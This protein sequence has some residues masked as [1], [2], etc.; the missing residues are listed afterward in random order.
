[1]KAAAIRTTIPS[2]GFF[3]L[4]GDGLQ[5]VADAYDTSAVT[6]D[7]AG[8]LTMNV[9]QHV[10]ATWDGSSSGSQVHSYIDGV[11]SDGSAS[12][13]G[14]NLKPDDSGQ[15]FTI[16]N[17]PIGVSEMNAARHPTADVVV[18]DNPEWANTSV[19]H[20]DFNGDGR[21]DMLMKLWVD[22]SAPTICSGW[23]R[24]LAVVIR[25]R[26]PLRRVRPPTRSFQSIGTTTAVRICRRQSR[27]A[28][29]PATATTAT[30]S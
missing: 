5:F 7:S 26:I 18:L 13:G 24:R 2:A 28:S 20:M 15:P 11:A 30:A 8:S 9:W 19:K 29:M 21:E 16:G 4:E 25:Y 17:R 27:F 3:K 14:G 6:R 23:Y 12:N 1:M 10:V 22:N